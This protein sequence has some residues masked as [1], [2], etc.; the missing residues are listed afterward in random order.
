MRVL[1]TGAFGNLG[2]LVLERLIA[3]GHRVTALD[4]A[5]P[6]NRKVARRYQATAH[7]AVRW[8]DIRDRAALPALV[9]GQHAV[10]H[11]AA[12]I[13]P[14][15]EENPERARAVN[16]GG[17]TN[18]LD[19]I[20]ASGGRPLF[21]FTS[22]L[23]VY[24][25]RQD[26]PPPRTLD[27]PLVATDHYSAHKIACE[28]MIRRRSISWVILRLGAMVDARMRH[29]DRRQA[30]LSLMLAA[31][32]RVEYVHPRDAATAIVHAL[33]RPDA[34][35][36][37]HLIGGGPSCQVTHLELLNAMT[38]ALGITFAASD[39][40]TAKLYADWVDTRASERLLTYQQHTFADFRRETYARFRWLRPLV[41]PFGGLAKVAMKTYL[42]VD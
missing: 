9:D 21:V 22:S 19:A 5:T 1:L 33:T 39:L 31:N 26:D 8:G 2:S 34:H 11:V 36:T 40:G 25:V 30:R 23:S 4:L 41:R 27:D 6:G 14:F 17:T 18:L 13:A 28:E 15:S 32:N 37:V 7:V 3:E 42:G 10:I 38:G 16:V 12:V 24:G 29:H 20:E 35:N